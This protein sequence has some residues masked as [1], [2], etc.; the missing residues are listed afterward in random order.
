MSTANID[1]KCVETI[2]FLAADAVQKANSGHPGMPVGMAPTAYT[3]WTKVMAHNPAD[4]QWLNRDRFVL[5]AGHG[6]T[7]LYSM[8]HLCGY[9]MSLEDLKGFRQWGTKTPGHPEYSKSLGIEVT[10]G[11]LGQGVSNAVGMGMAQKYLAS[12]FNREGFPIFD[13]R[14]YAICGDGCLQEGVTSEACSLAGHLGLDNVVVI[15]DDNSITIDGNTELSFTEDVKARFLAYHWNVIEV[16]GEGVDLAAIEAAIIQAKNTQ[17]KPTLIKLQTVIGYGAPTKQGTHGA[18]GAPFGDDEIKA[19]KENFGWDGDKTFVVPEEVKTEYAK[20]V[21]KGK[22]AQAA[23]EKM[24]AEYQIKYPELA[25]ELE[26]AL[27]GK[28]P[29][30]LD[31]FIPVFASDA[32]MATRQASGKT[33]AAVMPQL[34][35]V[36]GGSA[37]LTPSNNTGFTGAEDFQKDHPGGR[38]IRFGVR[39]HAMGAILNGISV[40]GLTRAYGGTFLVF[41]DYMRGAIR[42]AA[43][44]KYPSIFVLTHDSIGV[45][46][47]GP[48][49]QPVEHI[50]ALRVL[51][52]LLTFRPGD[53]NETA[54]AWKYVLEHADAPAALC[55]TRQGMPTLDMETYPVKQG[56]PRGAYVLVKQENPDVLL[57]ATGSEVS[58]ALEAGE[59]LAAQG[60]KAQVVSMPCWELY[61]RQDQ[62]YKDSVMPPTCEARVGVEAQV[63]QGWYKWLG[64]KGEFVGMKGFGSSGPCKTCFEE[65]GITADHVV[66]AAK[67]SMAK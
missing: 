28:L 52:N 32:A 34:P 18:H 42:V 1:Q 14:A 65:F 33:L 54:Q 36:L 29:V 67:K 46:E 10:T 41:S 58:V 13:Y 51:P 5:S 30:D 23:W 25:K 4:P 3:L 19:M 60:I 15:Y 31:D 62:A 20:V 47:D 12:R 48:T 9:D 38:Y 21:T 44:A 63:D 53:A 16:P 40:G 39:E 64:F 6:S 26:D 24:F 2:R 17:G 37:D 7:L 45:G 49:H 50:A 8:L 57:L 11:P 56:V 43:L 35:L 61:E 22:A 55:L 27:A 59:K 66:M